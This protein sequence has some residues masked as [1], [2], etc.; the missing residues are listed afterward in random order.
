[1]YGIDPNW[2]RYPVTWDR[3]R[4]HQIRCHSQFRLEHTWC[5]LYLCTE[6]KKIGLA[7]LPHET[8]AARVCCTIHDLE[9]RW[10]N[11]WT[12]EFVCRQEI[13][14]SRVGTSSQKKEEHMRINER[15]VHIAGNNP[16][17]SFSPNVLFQDLGGSYFKN[18]IKQDIREETYPVV[19]LK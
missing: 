6:S 13:F 19:G 15:T 18:W 17:P 14:S 16:L 9:N 5:G 1:M 8:E 10:R 4:A 11:T 12:S 3:I 7:T 2:K